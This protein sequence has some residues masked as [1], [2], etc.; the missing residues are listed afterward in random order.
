ILGF[1]APRVHEASNQL[2]PVARAKVSL[3]RAPGDDAHRALDT[4]A[5]HLEANAP[6]GSQ[7][8]I[9]RGSTGEPYAVNADGPV[10]DSARRAFR[11]AWG[12]DPVDMGSGGSIP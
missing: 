6:W 7:V 4:L 3:R 2:V 8:T 12:T 10:Y 5:K 9:S 11:D 1:A